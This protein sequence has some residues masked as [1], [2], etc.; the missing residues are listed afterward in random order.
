ME[1]MKTVDDVPA[2]VVVAGP[3][4][5]GEGGVN[6]DASTKK[7]AAGDNVASG[8]SFHFRQFDVTQYPPDHNFLL[9]D[10]EQVRMHN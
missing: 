9:H 10:K 6:G 5:C 2:G 8:D 1:M 3:A 7:Q 4:S